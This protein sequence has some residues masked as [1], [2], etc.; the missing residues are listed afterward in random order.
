MTASRGTGLVD[1]KPVKHMFIVSTMRAALT[2]EIKAL[3]C[4]IADRA[5]R[6]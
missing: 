3:D 6:E 5:F 4:L 1:F 2:P